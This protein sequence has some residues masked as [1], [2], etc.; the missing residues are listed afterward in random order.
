MKTR[1]CRKRETDTVATVG[2][3][4]IAKMYTKLHNEAHGTSI[5]SNLSDFWLKMSETDFL[6]LDYFVKIVIVLQTEQ[7]LTDFSFCRKSF[8]YIPL[9]YM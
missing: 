6:I 3:I 9:V 4:N 7:F 1:Q 8:L 2:I 5:A